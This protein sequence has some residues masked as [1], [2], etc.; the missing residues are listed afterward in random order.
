M[1]DRDAFGFRLEQQRNTARIDRSIIRN[2]VSAKKDIPDDA[3]ETLLVATIALKYTLSNSICIAYDGQV[4]GMGAGQQSRVHCTRLAC[5]KAEK[6]LLQQHP[7][8]LGLKFKDGLGRIE[9][10]NVVDSYLLWDELADAEK[11]AMLAQLDEEPKPLTARQ[12][13]AWVAKFDGICLSSDAF[14]PFRDT[15]DRASRTNVRYVL[16]TG[17]SLR[18]EDVTVA[19][20]QYGMVM[21]HSGLRLFLH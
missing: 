5:G 14:I 6:W 19:A 9:K 3:V 15:V 20:D 10:T 16:Q 21:V 7:R 1:E 4:I 11:D 8:V 17:G 18:D 2:V 13:A 12:R